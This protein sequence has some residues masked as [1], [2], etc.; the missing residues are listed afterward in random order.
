MGVKYINEYLVINQKE[1][2]SKRTKLKNLLLS[3]LV[4]RSF[5]FSF[6]GSS[7]SSTLPRAFH[8][9]SWLRKTGSIDQKSKDS[10]D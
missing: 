4:K 6:S 8:L 2:I 9:R 3:E 1:E 5:T 10:G 7:C